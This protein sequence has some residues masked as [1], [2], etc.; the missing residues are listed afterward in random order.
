MVANPDS[1]Q[2]LVFTFQS[3]IDEE[4][5]ISYFN[6]SNTLKSKI[7]IHYLVQQTS[8]Q[9]ALFLCRHN[10]WTDSLR[11]NIFLQKR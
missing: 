9:N 7:A 2:E 11:Q 4:T 3:Q 6:K 10:W 8:W 1:K 5:I